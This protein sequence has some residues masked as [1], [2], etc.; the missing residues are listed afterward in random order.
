MRM[1]GVGDEL[2]EGHLH[3][4]VPLREQAHTK[5]EA[6]A[7]QLRVAACDDRK[8]EVGGAKLEED[9]LAVNELEREGGNDGEIQGG[10]RGDDRGGAEE[11]TGE[12]T[13]RYKGG[14]TEI[15]ASEG[16]GRAGVCSCL[17]VG[18]GASAQACGGGVRRHAQPPAA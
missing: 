12:M 1:E 18:G 10:C 16:N 3:L 5:L 11:M 4:L 14:T 13:G 6:L 15:H 7:T 17:Q 8:A 2:V 9:L